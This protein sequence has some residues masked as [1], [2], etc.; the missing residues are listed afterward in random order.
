MRGERVNCPCWLEL[1][2]WFFTGEAAPLTG[3]SL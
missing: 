3:L 2:D 1:C